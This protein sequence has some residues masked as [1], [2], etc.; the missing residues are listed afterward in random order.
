MSLHRKLLTGLVVVAAATGCSRPECPEALTTVDL[1]PVSFE[2]SEPMQLGTFRPNGQKVVLRDRGDIPANAYHAVRVHLTDADRTPVPPEG[3]TWRVTSALD[4]EPTARLV[5][6][7][8]LRHEAYVPHAANWAADMVAVQSRVFAEQAE[9][10][11]VAE[12]LEGRAE[13]VKD[14]LDAVS[15]ST[16]EE[17][18]IPQMEMDRKLRFL[19]AQR[20]VLADFALDQKRSLD[21]GLVLTSDCEKCPAAKTWAEENGVRHVGDEDPEAPALRSFFAQVSGHPAKFPMMWTGGKIV[22]G[23]DSAEWNDVFHVK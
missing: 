19:R 15:P 1:E 7:L 10:S 5:T 13:E 2:W 14:V 3:L 9:T 18:E 12:G 20:P 11:E 16:G 22:Y 23:F 4:D 6:E 8:Q 21:R 17:F